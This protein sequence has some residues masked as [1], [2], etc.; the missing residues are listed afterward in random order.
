MCLTATCP[1]GSVRWSTGQISPVLNVASLTGQQTYS[2]VCE[3]SASCVSL[4]ASVSVSS[5]GSLSVGQ[6]RVLCATSSTA[7]TGSIVLSTTASQPTR[8]IV[9]YQLESQLA[10]GSY[11]IVSP[12]SSNTAL[13][14]SLPVGQYRVGCGAW[15][16]MW[17]IR[18]PSAG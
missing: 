5:I 10:P 7:A 11:T 1:T 2:A 13:L 8:M 17:L 15:V 9:Q 16:R 4:P 3:E 18:L 6:P 12:W 14:S